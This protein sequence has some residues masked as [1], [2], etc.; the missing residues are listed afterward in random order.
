MQIRRLEYDHSFDEKNAE[1][2]ELDETNTKQLQH[3]RVTAVI[4]AKKDHPDLDF[5]SLDAVYADIS[6]P[7]LEFDP[8]IDKLPQLE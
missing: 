3:L 1:W 5:G 6:E 4:A 2:K 7:Q 8:Q